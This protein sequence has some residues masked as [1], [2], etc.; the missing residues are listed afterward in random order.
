MLSTPLPLI[1]VDDDRRDIQ[2][3]PPLLA[4]VRLLFFLFTQEA[5]VDIKRL[6]TNFRNMIDCGKRNLG[7]AFLVGGN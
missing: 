1:I 7:F 2:R 4:V 6:E 5:V 3:T